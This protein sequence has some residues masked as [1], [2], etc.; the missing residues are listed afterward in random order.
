MTVT[1]LMCGDW[2]MF[3]KI[4]FQETPEYLNGQVSKID[5]ELGVIYIK[6][7]SC[8]YLEQ[9]I[10]PIPLTPKVLE[11]NGFEVQS[12]AYLTSRWY[13]KKYKISIMRHASSTDTLMHYCIYL[14]EDDEYSQLSYV[15]D[16]VCEYVH[17][18]QHILKLCKIDK[19]IVL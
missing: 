4:S 9:Q 5:S 6:G 7:K 2:V 10:K 19:E 8:C 17:E 1:N 14:K 13:D 12:G 3:E 11:K 16:F 18:L 15:P